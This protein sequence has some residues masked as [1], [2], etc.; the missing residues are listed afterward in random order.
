YYIY[1]QFFIIS[2]LLLVLIY[3]HILIILII[4]ELLVVNISI[5]IH[6]VIVQ[7]RIK[8]YLI[9]YLIFSVCER[10]LGLDLLMITIHIRGN[11]LYYI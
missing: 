10:A 4:I 8:F 7:V 1:M 11:D 9:C 3:K 6:T 2:L 5:I